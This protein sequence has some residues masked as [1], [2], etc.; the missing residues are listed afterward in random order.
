V[1]RVGNNSDSPTGLG[2]APR[3]FPTTQGSW[4]GELGS[5]GSYRRALDLVCERYWKPIYWYVRFTGGRTD[6]ESKDLTQAFLLWLLEDEPLRGYDPEKGRFRPY[7]K[8]L[9]KRFLGHDLEAKRRLKRGGGVRVLALDDPSFP[10]EA[11][12]DPSTA[13]PE[14]AFDRLWAM[15]L[16]RT[17]IDRVRERLRRQGRSDKFEAYAAIDLC[18]AEAVPSYREVAARLRVGEHDV[19][20]ALRDVRALI[21]E[22][23]RGDLAETVSRPEDLEA[24]WHELFG[25]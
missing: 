21:R 17:A 24:E 1:D 13:D 3:S 9:L 4:V 16:A 25:L 11:V 12:P 23:I 14:K 18:R 20:N 6:D 5:S 15:E 2:D 19:R 8:V 7:L 10:G 22:E